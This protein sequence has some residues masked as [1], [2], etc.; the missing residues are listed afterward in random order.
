M[1]FNPSILD[2]IN[3]RRFLI[4]G[5]AGFI[6]SNI[7]H[8]LIQLG[9][10]SVSVLDD[11]STGFES[12]I[13]SLKQYPS[14]KFIKADIRDKEACLH[15]CENVDIVLHQAALG[16]VP[17]SIDNPL[18]TNSVNVDGFLNVINAARLSG[19]TR[20]VYASSSSVYGD[21]TTMPKVEEK[22]GEL[23]SPY[24]VSKSANEKYAKVFSRVYGME[25][26]GLRYFNVFGPRQN[27]RGPYAAVIPLFIQCMLKGERP[28]IFGDGTNTRD[29]TFVENV[30]NANLLAALTPDIG[31]DSPIINIAFGGTISLNSLY[32]SLTKMADFT[33]P[34]IYANE[35]KGD[36]RNSYAD[37]S[38]AREIIDYTPS[39]GVEEG[40]RITLDWYKSFI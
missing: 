22:T 40:L 21:D 12:N 37:I 25:T 36:I 2:Q 19:V 20:F 34:P 15:V 11:L 18:L 10:S 17:R 26:V 6:G 38:K 33:M 7:A 31:K 16:S 27:I 5:G 13:E 24:A 9:A 29:F 30:V 39:V 32:D 28:T 4:T 8:R 35:R 1:S 14:F 23:L 3:Q